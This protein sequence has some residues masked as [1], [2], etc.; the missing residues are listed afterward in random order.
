MNIGDL[1]RAERENKGLS[2]FDVE[3]KTKIRSKYLQAL[4]EENFEEIPGEAYRIGFCAIMLA[5]SIL[6]LN[7]S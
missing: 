7:R 3:E 4:E 5:F 2:L 1:L 6:I